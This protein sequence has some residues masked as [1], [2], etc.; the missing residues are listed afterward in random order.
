LRPFKTTQE[1]RRRLLL[2]LLLLLLLCPQHDL[3]WPNLTM[4]HHDTP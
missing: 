4:T 3:V 1:E 2:L